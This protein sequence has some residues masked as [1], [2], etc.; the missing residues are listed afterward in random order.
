MLRD[1]MD[2]WPIGQLL[3]VMVLGVIVLIAMA[4]VAP[5]AVRG[6]LLYIVKVVAGAV[7][8]VCLLVLLLKGLFAIW[9]ATPD[10]RPIRDCCRAVAE[11]LLAMPMHLY[12]WGS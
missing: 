7:S 9:D 10:T 4:V 12:R 3:L 1:W 11:A 5:Y 2:D 6:S 8:L